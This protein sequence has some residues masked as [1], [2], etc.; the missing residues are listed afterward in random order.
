MVSPGGKSSANG[1]AQGGMRNIIGR[2]AAPRLTVVL[3]FPKSAALGNV[4]ENFSQAS[5][6]S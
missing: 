6:L 4:P 3:A 1:G 5:F 2:R